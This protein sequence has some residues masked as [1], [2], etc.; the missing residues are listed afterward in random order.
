MAREDKSGLVRLTLASTLQRLPVAQRPALAAPLLA[1]K[2]DASDHNLPLL[3]W[4]G[5]IPVADADPSGLARLASGCALPET[6]RFIARRLAE[7]LDK[8]PGPINELLAQVATTPTI[9]TSRPTSS[10]GSRRGSSA[11]GRR[12]SPRPG[13]RWRAGSRPPRM[14]RSGPESGT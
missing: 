12:R 4:Y 2:E 1:R 5:L 6:R 10:R 7:D 13:I 14:P 9:G 11:G 8:N 3:I